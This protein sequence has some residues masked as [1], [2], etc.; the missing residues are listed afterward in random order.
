[1]NTSKSLLSVL[2]AFVLLFSSCA[3]TKQTTT[4]PDLSTNNGTGARKTGMSK[5]AKGGLIGAGSGAAAGAILGRVI[6]GGRGTAIGA[7]VGAAAGGTAGALIGRKMDKAAEDLQRDMKDAKVERVGEGIKITFD[8]GILFD[9]NSSSLRPASESDITKMA[10]ILQKYP[11]TNVLI[12]GHTDN[13]GSDAINQPLSERRA[14]AVATSTIAKG[15][16]SS[17][18]TTQGYGSTQPVADNSTV[19]GKQANRRVE[20]AIYANEKMK[21]AAEEGRL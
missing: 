18:I 15:V 2:M 6:G 9:S 19:E 7:I 12:E 21:K 3:S 5:T 14:Q 11:D 4:Q 8:S 17:R 20:V 10:A 1:M 13:T 16:S